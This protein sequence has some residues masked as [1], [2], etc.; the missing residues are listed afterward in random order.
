MENEISRTKITKTMKIK[1]IKKDLWIK[2]DAVIINHHTIVVSCLSDHQ[3]TMT[4]TKEIM[5]GNRF[6]VCTR[7]NSRG[8]NFHLLEN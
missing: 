7:I 5:K 1:L 8:T 2:K 6:R 3:Q 4:K